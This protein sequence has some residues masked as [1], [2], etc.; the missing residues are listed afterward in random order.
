MWYVVKGESGR[1]RQRILVRQCLFKPGEWGVGGE[2]TKVLCPEE[3][4][5]LTGLVYAD[6]G[7]IIFEPGGRVKQRERV[8]LTAELSD[9]SKHA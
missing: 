5:P 9:V 3:E 1:R 8:K 2:G 6:S 7:G 4:T